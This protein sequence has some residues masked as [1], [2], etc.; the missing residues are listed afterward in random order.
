VEARGGVRPGE[1][2]K[3]KESVVALED[4]GCSSNSGRDNSHRKWI[5]GEH[6]HNLWPLPCEKEAPKG[7]YAPSEYRTKQWPKE[8]LLG[9]WFPRLSM[10]KNSF[11][12]VRR[13]GSTHTNPYSPARESGLNSHT[14][15]TGCGA[16]YSLK[17]C[18]PMQTMCFGRNGRSVV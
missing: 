8:A 3:V 16:I 9:E 5:E 6:P 15:Q 4:E 10:G 7:G 13:T 1:G 18:R 14:R 11:K 2:S 12:V 17:F